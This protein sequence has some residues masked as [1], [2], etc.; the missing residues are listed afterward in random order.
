[1]KLS[2]ALEDLGI[3]PQDLQV[4]TLATDGY[5]AAKHRL[6]AICMANRVENLDDIRPEYQMICGGDVEATKDVT[7]ILPLTYR[8]EAQPPEVTRQWF[9]DRLTPTTVLAGHSVCRFTRPFLEQLFGGPTDEHV[10]GFFDTQIIGRAAMGGRLADGLDESATLAMA[11]AKMSKLAMPAKLPK[12]LE[13]MCENY[14][15]GLEYPGWPMAPWQKA[16]RTMALLNRLL[17][18]EL[19]P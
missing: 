7:G 10:A 13:A 12:S 15:L 9:L 2:N 8:L 5:S 16:C 11:Q 17:D 4:I 1:M 6:L 18:E 14:Q 3:R 19:A